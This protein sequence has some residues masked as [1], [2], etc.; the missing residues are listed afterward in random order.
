MFAFSRNLSCT[1]QCYHNTIL[2][3][4]LLQLN[5]GMR[6]YLFLNRKIILTN[7]FLN[8]FPV[9]FQDDTACLKLLPKVREDREGGGRDEGFAPS[10]PP[11]LHILLVLHPAGDLPPLVSLL[12]E[13]SVELDEHRQHRAALS[14]VTYREEYFIVEYFKYLLLKYFW[15]EVRRKRENLDSSVDF[16]FDWALKIKYSQISNY[17]HS[18]LVK[19]RP[20]LLDIR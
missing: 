5:Q 10:L 13:P 6:E 20:S 14:S 18:V 7:N 9:R 1:F 15:A 4:I 12:H 3:Y 17:Y 8:I 19:I 16:P 2:T 11:V